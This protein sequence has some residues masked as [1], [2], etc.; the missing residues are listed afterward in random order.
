MTAELTFLDT[1][2][3]LYAHDRTAGRKQ[4]VARSLVADLWGSRTGV[5]GTQVL[6]EFYV[7]A[8]RKLPRPLSAPRA[9]SVID[10]YASWVVHRIEPADILEA[11]VLEKRHRLT[12]WDSLI[13]ISAA[14]AGAGVLTTEDL[15]HGRS[16]AGVTVIDPFAAGEGRAR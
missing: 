2:I 11:S 8:T 3:L 13:V 6:Q 10:R 14:R 1:N 5:L 4:E 15:Q 7:K 12:F 9:R 16:L